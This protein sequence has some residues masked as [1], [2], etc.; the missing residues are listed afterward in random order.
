MTFQLVTD[1][2][3]DL[4]FDVIKDNQLVELDMDISIGERSYRTVGDNRIT[5]DQLLVE[6]GKGQRPVT[7][8]VAIGEVQEVFMNCAKEGTEVLYLTFSSGLSGTFQSANIAREAVLE[9]FPEA[10]ITIVDSLAAASGEGYLLEEVLKWRDEGKTVEEIVELLKTLIPRLRSWFMVDDLNVL[11]R[12][13][14]ISKTVAVVGTMASIKPV[15]DVDPS[16]HLRAVSKA[17]GT[18]KAVSMLINNT[19]SEF[20]EAYPRIIVSY[21]GASD[22]AEAAKKEFFKVF[23]NITVDIRPLGPVISAH[24]GSGTIAI[25]SV[26]KTK[27]A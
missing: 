19:I 27:R 20:D 25:F 23:P 4:P 16:G 21:S 22:L 5:T 24:T 14:R 10:K 13:G 17:R 7:S 6:L 26:G 2:T 11:A 15:L 9:T 12:G 1:A 8:A 18:K 3:A